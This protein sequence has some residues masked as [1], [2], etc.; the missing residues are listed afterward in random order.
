MWSKSTS[1][2]SKI[3]IQLPKYFSGEFRTRGSGKVRVIYLN[4]KNILCCQHGDIHIGL[5]YENLLSNQN[6]HFYILWFRL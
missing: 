3:K 2:Q 6:L 1:K 4:V 5:S